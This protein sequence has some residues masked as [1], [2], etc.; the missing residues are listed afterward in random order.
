[1]DGS[2]RQV[3]QL[4]NTQLSSDPQKLQKLMDSPIKFSQAQRAC[5]RAMAE[6]G[7]ITMDT[8]PQWE[9]FWCA[10]ER[11][12]ELFLARHNWGGFLAANHKAWLAMY[13]RGLPP[14]ADYGRIDM[15]ELL[16]Y[17]S[18]QPYGGAGGSG[19]SAGSGSGSGRGGSSGS[20]ASKG[21]EPCHLFQA[22]KCTRGAACRYAHA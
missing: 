20:G 21:G 12:S 18:W 15:I 8:I 4:Q 3:L 17:I 7:F 1:V 10:W 13:E 11:L 19:G 6:A 2:G 5:M 22:G 16:Q 9:V 14:D